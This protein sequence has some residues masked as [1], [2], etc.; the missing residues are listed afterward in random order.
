M[1]MSHT[2]V[3]SCSISIIVASQD[4]T[5]QSLRTDQLV[6]LPQQVPNSVM[7]VGCSI[8]TDNVGNY[9]KL[10]YIP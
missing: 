10:G 4:A 9:S 2:Y 3:H 6:S 5:N 1:A 7:V 8:F